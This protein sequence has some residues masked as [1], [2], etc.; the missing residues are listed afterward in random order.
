MN[1]CSVF[2]RLILEH[3]T[4]V[5]LN[6]PCSVSD[7]GGRLLAKVN[8]T[9]TCIINVVV[10]VE[11]LLISFTS[12]EPVEGIKAKVVIARF[13]LHSYMYPSLLLRWVSLSVEENT[14][15]LRGIEVKKAR[16]PK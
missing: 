9:K 13:W 14:I 5:P 15:G 8:I 10:D 1:E 7:T 11:L 2:A 3:K 12:K 4:Y 6:L 16:S